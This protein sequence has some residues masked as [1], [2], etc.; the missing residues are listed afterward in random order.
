MCFKAI[1]AKG[2]NVQF[3]NMLP[4]LHTCY[5][6]KKYLG[7]FCHMSRVTCHMS[8]V[9]CHMC[10]MSFVKKHIVIFLYLKKKCIV[11]ND[12]LVQVGVGSV[13]KGAHPF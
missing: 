5:D 8:L 1:G 12:V 6:S 11:L 3:V 10:H 13:I 7:S 4:C 9:A 2:K